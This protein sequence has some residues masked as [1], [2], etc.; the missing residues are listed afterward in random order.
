VRWGKFN[1]AFQTETHS[2]DS[3]LSEIA[4]GHSFCAALSGYRNAERFVSSQ[5]L[6]LDYDSGNPSLDDLL[7]DTYIAS[8]GTFIY[9][10]LS[11]SE[12]SRKWRVVFVLSEP[13]T[14]P[15]VYRKAMTALLDRYQGTDQAIKDPAR[16]LYGSHP[17]SGVCKFMGNLLPMTEVL[18][19]LSEYDEKQHALRREVERRQLAEIDRSK[20]TGATP[21]EKYVEIAIQQELGYLA[22]RAPGSGERYPSVIPTTMKLESLRLSEW[23]SPEARSR[24][25]TVAIVLDGCSRNGSLQHYGADHLQKAINFGIAHAEPRPIPPDWGQERQTYHHSPNGHISKNGHHPE[26]EVPDDQ[27]AQVGRQPTASETP[28]LPND[29][30]VGWLAAY[31]DWVFP[32]TDGSIEGIFGAASVQVG[33]AMGRNVGVHYGVPTFTNLFVALCGPTGVPRKTTLINRSQSLQD[34]AFT[35]DFVR[36]VRSIGSGEGLLERFCH[37]I[38]EGTGKNKRTVLSP[39]PGQR[40]LLDEPELTNLLKKMRR[41]GT[42]NI[43]EI[44]LGLFDGADYSPNTRRRPIVVTEPFFSIIT[45]TTPEALE[46]TLNDVDI[47]SGL[48]PRVATFWCTPREP[49]A[50]PPPPDQVQLSDLAST[51]QDVARFAEQ[52]H[53]HDPVLQ[54]SDGARHEWE[55]IYRDLVKES[56]EAPKAVG[57]IMARVPTMMMKWALLYAVQNYHSIIEVD[58][59]ARAVLVG[60]YLM[61][62]ARLVP[63]HVEKTPIARIEARILDGMGKAPDKWWRP[64]DIHQKVGGRISAPELRRSLES[65]AAL[66]KLDIADASSGRTQIYRLAQG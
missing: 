36:V 63:L 1:G 39:I 28:V 17:K 41:P 55:S 34:R 47:D 27:I 20:L 43:A 13:I 53:Q 33:L 65:L 11:H 35:H 29:V 8:Y 19:L 4:A 12:E 21:D 64:K 40:V 7:T 52:L 9:S 60:D 15:Q 37:E 49:I 31:R 16:F 54:L 51:L 66:G 45:A 26:A 32:T 59:L 58:D 56:R 2:P 61:Q 46:S 44:L 5:T 23:L 22:T 57:G 25:D 42:A 18:K 30:W 48:I 6:A 50:W 62:T 24:L 38:E 10:T 3:L 14:D